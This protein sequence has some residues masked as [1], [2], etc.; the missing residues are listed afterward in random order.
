MSKEI[1]F[2][3]TFIKEFPIFFAFIEG[4]Y[5]ILCFYYIEEDNVMNRGEIFRKGI[6]MKV[7]ERIW[8]STIWK[9]DTLMC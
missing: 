7:S 8:N 4:D 1:N 3:F 9:E 5:H 6:K 2:L